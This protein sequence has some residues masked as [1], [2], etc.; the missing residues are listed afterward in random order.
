VKKILKDGL[1][2]QTNGF[3]GIPFIT[4]GRKI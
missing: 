1:R 3:I 4:Q 2:E